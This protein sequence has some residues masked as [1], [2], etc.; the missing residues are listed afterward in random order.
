MLIRQLHQRSFLFVTIDN[1][2]KKGFRFEQ[3]FC[4]GCHDI[5]MTSFLIISLA[6]LNIHGL[7]YFLLLLEVLNVKPKIY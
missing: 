7:D 1:F 2:L 4:N 5:L 6:V 3:T